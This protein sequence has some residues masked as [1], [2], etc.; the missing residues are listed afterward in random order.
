MGLDSAPE[1]ITEDV[2]SAVSTDDAFERDV[3]DLDIPGFENSSEAKDADDQQLAE[4]D[5]DDDPDAPEKH[6][7]KKAE[8]EAEQIATG[9]QKAPKKLTFRAGDQSVELAE[10]AIV[11]HKI[12]G[13]FADIPLKELITNYAGKVA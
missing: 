4:E 8:Q 3:D 10:D 13:K 1:G 12:D 6:Q 2:I 7:Q 11:Q 9:A 5:E